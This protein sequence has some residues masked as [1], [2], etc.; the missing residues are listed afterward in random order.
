MV[1]FE[2]KRPRNL[3]A[4]RLCQID[5]SVFEESNLQM[6]GFTQILKREAVCRRAEEER[7]RREEEERKIKE[8][9]VKEKEEGEKI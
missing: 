2:A 1:I 9:I 6:S 5:T 4:A 3:K 8:Q 7:L